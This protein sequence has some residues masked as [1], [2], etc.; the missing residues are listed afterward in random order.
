[1]G[2]DTVQEHSPPRITANDITRTADLCR[3]IVKLRK[4]EQSFQVPLGINRTW[5][6]TRLFP[7]FSSRELVFFSGRRAAYY[8]HSSMT[9]FLF[10]GRC[11]SICQEKFNRLA[12]AIKHEELAIKR[13]RE[14]SSE[15]LFFRCTG[16]QSCLHLP[17]QQNIFLQTS[18]HIYHI[19]HQNPRYQHSPQGRSMPGG[20]DKS[21]IGKKGYNPISSVMR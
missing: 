12:L 10:F 8:P 18:Y 20:L 19:Y 17:P 3:E 1:M 5:S 6:L 14:E 13:K 4:R 15:D 16:S 21:G 2:I 11:P 7:L 9:C